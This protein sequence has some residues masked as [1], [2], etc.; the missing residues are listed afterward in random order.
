MKPKVLICVDWFVPGYKAGGPIQSCKNLVQ[1]LKE[2][3]DFVILTSDRDWGET[4]PYPSV[5]ADTWLM[6]DNEVPILYASPGFLNLNKLLEII[7]DVKPDCLYL[8]SMFSVKFTIFPLLLRLRNKVN[9]RM[10][11]APRGMLQG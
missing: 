2:E 5:Q 3:I 6:Y 7:A 1:G 9:T 10:I 8:N 4:S 11:L